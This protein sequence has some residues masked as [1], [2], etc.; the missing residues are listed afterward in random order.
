M[1]SNPVSDET[2]HAVSLTAANEAS[3]FLTQATMGA[4]YPLISQV[5]SQGHEEWLEAQFNAPIGLTIPYADF[6]TARL[7]AA[8]DADSE[9][10]IDALF[11]VQ[12]AP[13]SYFG[14][15]WWTQAMT[16]PD[17]VR[18][19]VATALTEIFV[20]GTTVEEIGENPIALATYY[21]LLLNNSF[22]NFKDLLL[23]VTMSPA[24]G[25]YLSHLGNAR[26]NSDKGTFPDENYARE[27][28]QLFSIGLFELNLDG[29]HK[30]DNSGNPIP[31]YDNNTIREFAKVFTG[32]GNGGEE[33]SFQNELERDVDF[34]IPMSMYEPYHDNTSKQLL[35]GQ[36]LSAGQSGLQDIQ[37]AIDNLFNHPNVG[38][39]FGRLLIQRLVTSNPSPAYIA[40]VSAA[41][42]GDVNS[43]RG[44]MKAV[45]RAILLDPEATNPPELANN[46]QGKLRE[47]MLRVMHLSRAF[48]AV[49][50]DR[51]YNDI[52]DSLHEATKQVIFG[53][54]SV[55]NFFQSDYSPLGE[56]SRNELVSPEFQITSTSSIIS[57]KNYLAFALSE[58]GPLEE[59]LGSAVTR[60]QLDAE[61]ALNDEELLNRLDTKLTYGTMTPTTR[62]VVSETI[63]NLEGEQKV[64]T[65]IYLIMISPDYTTAI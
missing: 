51:T 56:L 9:A 7:N 37:G 47:P 58:D 26:A 2:I 41:F 33:P 43:K 22:G 55:F 31:T 52:G 27:V 4:N 49:S 30:L 45:I 17:L 50:H 64:R 25:V 8:E 24:M 20:I 60:L 63:A 61:L 10:D 40:R 46:A 59:E 39:F 13:E 57:V 28:M 29:S 62:T 21:D 32:L 65:A 54:P 36:V 11:E 35:N 15:A 19:R 6:L 16:S 44:D 14:Y 38:P 5:A 48:N 23:D 1:N 53:S 42:E 3:R 12:G 34:S 18:Q